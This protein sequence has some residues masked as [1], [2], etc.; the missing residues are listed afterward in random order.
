MN[1]VMSHD[2]EYSAVPVCASNCSLSHNNKTNSLII[3]ILPISCVEISESRIIRSSLFSSSKMSCR[4]L[5][6]KT[7]H[8]P[9]IIIYQYILKCG[10]ANR[11]GTGGYIHAFSVLL[12][13]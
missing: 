2:G 7:N 8:T 6:P 4:Y 9:I 10:F 1:R 3:S 11:R 5:F 12:F 13:W